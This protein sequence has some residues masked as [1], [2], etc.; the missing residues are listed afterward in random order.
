[1]FYEKEKETLTIKQL[2]KNIK[3]IFINSDELIDFPLG[4]SK[5]DNLYYVGGFH[6]DNKIIEKRQKNDENMRTKIIISLEN[7]ERIFFGEDRKAME[8]FNEIYEKTL[9]LINSDSQIGKVNFI[10][11]CKI[12][13][14][15]DIVNKNEFNFKEN[16]QIKNREEEMENQIF[17]KRFNIQKIPSLIEELEK[18]TTRMLIINCNR[19]QVIEAIVFNVQIFCLPYRDDQNYVAEGL[20]LNYF[21][22]QKEKIGETGQYFFN[23]GV[24]S[25][26]QISSKL[27]F[28][29]N[30]IKANDDKY[31][32]YIPLST[33]LIYA[34][35]ANVYK[36]Q[37][38]YIKIFEDGIEKTFKRRYTKTLNKIHDDLIKKWKQKHPINLFLEVIEEKTKDLQC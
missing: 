13:E 24:E 27:S 9:N 11:D 4:D 8:V 6:S 32:D 22:V 35:Y 36:R 1:M 14:D 28:A 37:R 38:K 21:Q 29:E 25:S 3:A 10:Y 33:N 7:C 15:M 16:E 31:I 2:Y 34:M 5:P 18:G 30:M 26:Y 20:K 23:E 12:N 19:N 17:Y